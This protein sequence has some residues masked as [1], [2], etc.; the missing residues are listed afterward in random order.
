MDIPPA[1]L[2]PGKVIL[3]ESQLHM[4]KRKDSSGT[5]RAARKICACVEWFCMAPFVCK[6]KKK[7]FVGIICLDLCCVLS[8]KRRWLN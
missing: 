5:L 1:P 4:I 3:Y 8:A 2:S 6:C 7:S